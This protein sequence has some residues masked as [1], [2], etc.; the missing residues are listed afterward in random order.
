MQRPKVSVVIPNYNHAPYL[1]ERVESVLS[2]TYN[3]LEVLILDDASSDESC[4]ILA[5]Y[6][7]R[8][9]VYIL[10]NSRNSGTAF[11]Q[12]N[13]GISRARGKYIWIAESDDSAD[14]RFLETLVPLLDENPQIGLAYCESLLINKDG[15]QTGTSLDWTSDLDSVRWKTD[16]VNNGRDEIRNYLIRKNTI[17]N[18]SAV[19]IRHSVLSQTLPVDSTF[20]LCGDW[21]HWGKMLLQSDIAHVAEPL[22][23]WRLESS[24]SRPLSPGI[25]EWKEGQRV[26]GSLA[27]ALG[28]TDSE[29]NAALVEFAD[30]CLGWLGSTA[31]AS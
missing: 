4:D 17:P 13:R 10:V 3:D 21:L 22:N 18:A 27:H 24:N 20:K 5:R 23:Y 26:I 31:H 19:L 2:Q 25:L 12:W 14:P 15:T 6:Y 11:S 29:V 16:F 8:P 28:Y 9:N 7:S 30:R 1:P